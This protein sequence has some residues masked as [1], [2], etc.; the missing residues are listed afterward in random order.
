LYGH[1]EPVHVPEMRSSIPPSVAVGDPA[2]MIRPTGRP[3]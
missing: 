2:V 1:L 3:L